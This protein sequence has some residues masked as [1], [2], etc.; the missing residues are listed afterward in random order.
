MHRRTH[1]LHIKINVARETGN[2]SNFNHPL[3]QRIDQIVTA[4]TTAT[5]TTTTT[6]TATTAAATTSL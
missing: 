5:T 3:F 4:T 1:Q 2:K 6:T